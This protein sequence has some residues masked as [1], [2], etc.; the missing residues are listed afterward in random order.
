MVSLKGT[1]DGLVITLGDGEWSQVLSELASQLER[2]RAAQFFHGVRARL[3]PGERE[4]SETEIDQLYELLEQHAIQIELHAPVPL[5]RRVESESRAAESETRA[6]EIETLTAEKPEPGLW[7]EAALVRRTVRSGQ[8][9]RYPG[10][11]IVHGDVNPGAEII[12]GGD[13]LIWG[14]LRGLVHAGASGD[15]KAVV[16]ALLL[17]P[18]QLRIGSHIARAPDDRGK[19][20]R[21]AEI[22]R[23]RDGRIVIESWKAGK[24]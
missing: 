12:A 2:P 3:A 11:V 10:C 22:A 13:V 16:G 17:A 21:G 4:L 18:M 15:E 14:K 19:K 5:P 7:G 20:D 6:V 9:I 8:I 23:V 24:D 1:K